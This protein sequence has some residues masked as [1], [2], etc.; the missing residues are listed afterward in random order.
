MRS[1]SGPVSRVRRLCRSYSRW[2]CRTQR[3]DG[4]A[5]VEDCLLDSSTALRKWQSHIEVLQSKVAMKG[6][7]VVQRA[8][9]RGMLKRR[10]CRTCELLTMAEDGCLTCVRYVKPQYARRIDGFLYVE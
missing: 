6:S 5:L 1:T 8:A 2:L 10:V 3:G 4:A 7:R 9:W